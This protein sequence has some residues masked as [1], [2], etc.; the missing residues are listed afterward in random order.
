MRRIPVV[1]FAL[2]LHTSYLIPHTCR[3]DTIEPQ[4]EI[5]IEA[6][7]IPPG[8]ETP[9]FPLIITSAM[10]PAGRPMVFEASI[11]MITWSRYAYWSAQPEPTLQLHADD[12][13]ALGF[14]HLNFRA[15]LLH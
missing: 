15:R 6:V 14:D 2:L 3:A 13:M 9:P 10:Q 8:P 4:P 1:L 7:T 5:M 11:D 12:W